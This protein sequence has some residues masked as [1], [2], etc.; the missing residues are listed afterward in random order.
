MAA[1]ESIHLPLQTPA[2]PFS[3]PDTVSGRLISFSD[4]RGARGTVIY[5]ICNHCPY[6]V[7]VRHELANVARHYL[8]QGIGFAAI[9]SNDVT[10]YPDDSPEKMKLL[11]TELAFPF[12]YLYDETQQVARAYHAACTPDIYLFDGADRL[13]YHG[14]LDD[15]RPGNGKPVN[16]ASLRAAIDSLLAQRHP[17]EKQLP[18]VGCS[19]KWKG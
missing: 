5:F 17:P 19:I 6:V 14:Q 8:P 2:P 9:S 16:G 10:R 12:P 11:A 1:I 3:L 13:Y 15:S 4:I 7:H 18:S